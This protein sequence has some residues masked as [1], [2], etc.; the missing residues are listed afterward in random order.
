MC[1]LLWLMPSL[2]WVKM[3]QLKVKGNV[4]ELD[5][6]LDPYAKV[7]EEGQDQ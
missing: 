5:A 1:S 7:N 4:A 6:I 2:G 3:F